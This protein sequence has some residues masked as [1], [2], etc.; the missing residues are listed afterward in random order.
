MENFLSLLVAEM[1]NQ[2]PLEPTSN[3]DYMAQMATFSQVEATTEMNEKVLP[4]ALGAGAVLSKSS[5]N[6]SSNEEMCIRDRSIDADN[7]AELYKQ[8][9]KDLEYSQKIKDWAEAY[10]KMD[11]ASAAAILEEMTGDT[12]LVSQILQCM[13]S[14]Q[15]AAVLAE[16]DPV[17]AAKITK[18][19][20]P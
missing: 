17:Y 7:A 6:S 10:A 11:A 20:H 8:V 1:Q 16:M 14:K 13:T 18:I 4:S 12:N 2:D 19:T 3:S 5:S 9:I 15:R